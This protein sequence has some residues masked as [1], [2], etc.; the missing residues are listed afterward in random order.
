MQSN[1]TLAYVRGLAIARLSLPL[2]AALQA[3]EAFLWADGDGPHNPDQALDVLG[4]EA[5]QV[6]ALSADLRKLLKDLYPTC[7]PTSRLSV[8]P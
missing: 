2:H 3:I 6:L 1:A 7:T 5:G 4:P 8:W